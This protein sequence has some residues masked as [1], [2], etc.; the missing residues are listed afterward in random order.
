M[1]RALA[2][3]AI[4]FCVITAFFSFGFFLWV[5]FEALGKLLETSTIETAL[6]VLLATLASWLVG[7]LVS[8][9]DELG[10]GR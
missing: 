2:C 8:R 5:G 10:G 1:K 7:E 3:I 4:G 6:W 9:L